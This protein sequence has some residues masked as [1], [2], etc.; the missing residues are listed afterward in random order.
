LNH[1]LLYDAGCFRFDFYERDQQTCQQACQEYFPVEVKK[2][3]VAQQEFVA[4]VE[5]YQ[6]TTQFYAIQ[7]KRGHINSLFCF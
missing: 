6:A 5:K 7:K 4:C 1:W 3:L 2:S